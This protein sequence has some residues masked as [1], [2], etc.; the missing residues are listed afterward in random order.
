MKVSELYEIFKDNRANEGVIDE[1]FEDVKFRNVPVDEI[2]YRLRN[3]LQACVV[4][5]DG[6]KTVDHS[7][8]EV[9]SFISMVVAMTD[10]EF[11]SVQEGGEDVSESDMINDYDMLVRMNMGRI[12]EVEEPYGYEMFN[13][14]KELELKNFEETNGV[15]YATRRLLNTVET[16]VARLADVISNAVENFNPADIEKAQELLTKMNESV[17]DVSKVVNF[18]PAE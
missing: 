3:T 5:E 2:L 8:W 9:A 15:D 12:L 14:F 18:K 1:V 10:L 16:S 11:S 17:Q 4:E 13:K 7:Y 6:V